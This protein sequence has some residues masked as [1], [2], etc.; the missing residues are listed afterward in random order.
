V[1]SILP[2]QEADPGLLTSY[3][4]K[5]PAPA[6]A[7]VEPARPSRSSDRRRREVVTAHLGATR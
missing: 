6:M 5:D 3:F 2:S 4:E 1:G 7:V